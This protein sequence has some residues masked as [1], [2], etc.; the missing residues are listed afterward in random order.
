MNQDNT[1]TR[2]CLD[3]SGGQGE[4]EAD[5][6]HPLA[7]P[8]RLAAATGRPPGMWKYLLARIADS[9]ELHLI[10]NPVRGATTTGFPKGLG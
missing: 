6:R 9:D 10:G 5:A 2:I 1:D 3:F 7:G 8:F 4:V